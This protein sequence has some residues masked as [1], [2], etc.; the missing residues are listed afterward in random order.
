MPGRSLKNRWEPRGDLPCREDPA[1][2]PRHYP[3]RGLVGP[4]APSRGTD[5]PASGPLILICHDGRRPASRLIV[6]GLDNAGAFAFPPV[7]GADGWACHGEDLP[8]TRRSCH[9]DFHWKSAKC[10]EFS[11]LCFALSF[12]LSFSAPFPELSSRHPL[13]PFL[14]NGYL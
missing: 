6:P 13:P 2:L 1:S 7:P 4:V 5:V 11:Y 9:R 3:A 14:E 12:F 10:W 8:Q